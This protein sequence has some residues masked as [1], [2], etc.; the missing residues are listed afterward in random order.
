MAAPGPRELEPPARDPLDLVGPVLHRVEHRAVLAN[1]AGAEVEAA[2]Q[3]PD[4]EQV[5]PLAARGPEVRVDVELAAKAQEPLLG[6]HLGPVEARI[7]DSAHEHRVGVAGRGER[8]GRQ[9]VAGLEDRGAAEQVLLEL[10]VERQLAEDPCRCGGHL[11][12][13]AVS[14]KDGDLHRRAVVTAPSEAD[15]TS[16]AYLANTPVV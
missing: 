1:P 13:D 6:T 9:R 15:E 11:G 10:E 3:L 7:A 5:D 14:G 12:P 16:A 8:F 2:D 4:D